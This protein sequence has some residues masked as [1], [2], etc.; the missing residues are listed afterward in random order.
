MTVGRVGEDLV[1][2]TLQPD[3]LKKERKEE[4]KEEEERK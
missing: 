1:E 2:L 4:R 3:L